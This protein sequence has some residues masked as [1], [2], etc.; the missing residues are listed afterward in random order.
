MVTSYPSLTAQ[1]FILC[2]LNAFLF[3]G[4]MPILMRPNP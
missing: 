4:K 2:D 1:K 3:A